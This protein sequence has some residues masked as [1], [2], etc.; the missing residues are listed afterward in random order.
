MSELSN[1]VKALRGKMSA[2]EAGQK[3]G[4]SRE[5]FYRVER[6][7]SVK[8]ESLRDIATGLHATESDWLEMIVAWLKYQ[9]GEDAQKL[10]IE[11]RVGG[12]KLS[13]GATNQVG[14]AMLLFTDLNPADRVEITKAMERPEVRACLP[15]INSVWEKFDPSN[16]SD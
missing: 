10:W 6:G 3:C 7:G 14:R 16:R 2:E 13:D 15:A 8:F 4:L 11:P 1:K 5:S 12:S 9:I